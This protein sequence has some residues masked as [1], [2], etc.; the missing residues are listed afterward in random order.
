[1]KGGLHKC[2]GREE[3]TER[4]GEGCCKRTG[5]GDER[6][7]GERAHGILIVRDVLSNLKPDVGA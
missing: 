4:D 1:M 7:R 6:K 5:E 3:K 2:R